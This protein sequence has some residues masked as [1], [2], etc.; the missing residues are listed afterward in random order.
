MN[1]LG[2][3]TAIMLA[4]V[5][6]VASGCTTWSGKKAGE[7]QVVKI[8]LEAKNFSILRSAIQ[9][10]ASCQYLF[11]RLGRFIAMGPMSA[12]MNQGAALGGPQQAFA[13]G[14]ALGQPDLYA[15][16]FADLRKKADLVGKSA[17]L[18]NVVQEDVLTDYIVIG[19]AKLTLT[20]DVISFTDAYVD[21][22]RR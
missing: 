21:Y 3:F 13:G 22:A 4:A 18:Y 12:F 2:I 8:D 6:L 14:I 20:A 1:R 7:M 16:A 11:P 5:I 15:R 9:G 10:S 17:H 19:D